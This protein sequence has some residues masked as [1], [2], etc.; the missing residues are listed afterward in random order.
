[1]NQTTSRKEELQNKISELEESLTTLKDAL[2]KEEEAEQHKAIDQL[3]CC[4]SEIND[5]FANL[6]EFWR[7]LKEDFNKVFNK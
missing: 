6:Q 7:L 1:M 3:E 2:R 5:R 4:F